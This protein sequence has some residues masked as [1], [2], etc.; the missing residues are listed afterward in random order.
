MSDDNLFF[1]A[2]K[3]KWRFETSKGSITTE[4][5]FDL[6]LKSVKQLD[7]DTVA[8]ETNKKLKEQEEDSFV[9]VK[10]NP[11]RTLLRRQ[12]ELIKLVI[13]HKMVE[14]AEAQERAVRASRRAVLEG[15][16][17]KSEEQAILKM[18]PEQIKAEL[19]RL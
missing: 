4:Q 1:L 14:A 2:A 12:L 11:L 16:L 8:K 19:A 9:E 3:N 17:L 6:P 10:T 15:A 18:T 7:L 13:N 5:L